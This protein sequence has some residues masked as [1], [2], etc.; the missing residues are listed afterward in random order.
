MYGNARLTMNRSRLE[1]KP[2]G[3]SPPTMAVTWRGLG[4]AVL[5]PAGPLPAGFALAG[6]A[7]AGTAVVL[8]PGGTAIAIH[9]GT[10]GAAPGGMAAGGE[11]ELTGQVLLVSLD[12][13]CSLIARRAVHPD[14]RLTLIL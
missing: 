1:M 4:P 5:P 14:L 11:G 13:G 10:A 2:A 8:A 9:G 12:S 6:P 3:D 7:G